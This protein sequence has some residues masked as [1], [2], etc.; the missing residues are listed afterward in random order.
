VEAH[1][2]EDHENVVD[3]VMPGLWLGGIR[4]LNQLDE[5][6]IDTVVTALSRDT[7]A[8]ERLIRDAVGP[9]RKHLR[10]YWDDS[11][12]Q[13]LPLATLCMAA[14]LMDETIRR[15]GQV[16][17]HCWAGH[18]RSVSVVLFY[19]MKKTNQFKTL[20]QALQ[21]VQQRRP[22]AQPNSHFLDQLTDLIEQ[23]C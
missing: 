22:T 17:V 3:Q 14:K 5:L 18:S 12:D 6:R 11:H 1:A 4:A 16:L 8:S 20:E 2:D 10:I 7:R 15:G 13:D 23:P 9:K 21:Y 19:L